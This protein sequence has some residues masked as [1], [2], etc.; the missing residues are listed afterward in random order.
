MLVLARPYILLSDPLPQHTSLDNRVRTNNRKILPDPL[1]QY[2][3]FK[4][5]RLVRTFLLRRN[6]S[7]SKIHC[8]TD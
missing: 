4:I 5:T 2:T 8:Y 3:S 6:M 1:P 7:L